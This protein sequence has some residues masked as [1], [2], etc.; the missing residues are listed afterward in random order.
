VE[1]DI[2]REAVTDPEMVSVEVPAALAVPFV[3][4][5]VA[6]LVVSFAVPAVVPAVVPL[7]DGWDDDESLPKHAVSK[8]VKVALIPS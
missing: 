8:I 5:L 7:P 4:S 6:P 3:V 1:G 2:V